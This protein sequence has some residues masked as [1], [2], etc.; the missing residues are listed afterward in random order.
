MRADKIEKIVRIVIGLL[1][2][3]FLIF[4]LG[5]RLGSSFRFPREYYEL[6]T[7]TPTLILKQGLFLLITTLFLGG[8][9]YAYG[10]IKRKEHFN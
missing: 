1:A 9:I 10:K 8:V 5:N 2:S 4:L 3:L 6:A 7:E